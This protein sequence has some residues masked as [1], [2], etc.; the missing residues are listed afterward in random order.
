MLVSV[1]RVFAVKFAYFYKASVIKSIY[2]NIIIAIWILVS[3]VDALPF[4]PLNQQP[5]KEQC[6]YV[7]G[8]MW[9]ICVTVAFNII[10]FMITIINFFVIWRIA[11]KITVR[12]YSMKKGLT[13]ADSNDKERDEYAY[14]PSMK[15]K[16]VMDVEVSERLFVGKTVVN[17]KISYMYAMRDS[18]DYALNNIA[19]V[20]IDID[21]QSSPAMGLTD[22]SECTTCFMINEKIRLILEMRATKTSVLLL[23]VYTVCWTPLGIYQ[24][25][26]Y[27]CSSWL[28]GIQ[29]EHAYIDRFV[30]KVLSLLSSIFLPVV[31]CWKTKLFRKE[32]NR[33]STRIRASVRDIP[34]KFKKGK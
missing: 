18:K 24:F 14:E 19:N 12:A 4:F 5:D 34:T 32:A 13:K 21:H 8:H 27:I 2:I 17:R 28:S 29:H 3:V 16:K 11:S 20:E 33:L 23:L 26:E 10:P 22:D 25:V 31:Y 1:D 30:L 9:G 15:F 6:T 7:I